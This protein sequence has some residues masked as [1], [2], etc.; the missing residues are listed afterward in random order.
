MLVNQFIDRRFEPLNADNT[1]E[2]ALNRMQELDIDRLPVVDHLAGKLIGEVTDTQLMEQPVP[3]AP[4]SSVQL[5]EAAPV[6]EDQHIFEAIRHMLQ[7]EV[8][9]LPVVDQDM[10][11]EGAI[12]KKDVLEALSDLLNLAEL[13]SILTIDMEQRDFTLSEIVH[14]I[15]LEGAKILG[16]GVETPTATSQHFRVSVKLNIR[17]VDAVTSA[18]HRYGYHVST[19]SDHADENDLE[20]RANALL[21]YLDI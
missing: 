11:Y 13:G 21:H 3:E 19:D 5:K 2:D 15:E 6:Y 8:R 12:C 17:D 14:L 18:L 20:S 16:I 7:Q 4:I 1:I 10:T 9:M